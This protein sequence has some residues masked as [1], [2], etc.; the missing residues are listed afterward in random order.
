MS[1]DFV[2]LTVFPLT[3]P[4]NDYI[5]DRPKNIVSKWGSLK[6]AGFNTIDAV[7]PNPVNIE[8]AY[9]FRGEQYVLIYIQQGKFL[10]FTLSW[11]LVKLTLLFRAKQWLYC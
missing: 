10:L 11:N 9:F 1:I 5:I 7:L 8:Q 6:S 4:P 3:G 2:A